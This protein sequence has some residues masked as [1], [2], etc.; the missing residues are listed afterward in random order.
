MHLCA[1]LCLFSCASEQR[2]QAVLDWTPKSIPAESVQTFSI[3][4]RESDMF[5]PWVDAYL[6]GGLRGVERLP[7][8]RNTYVFVKENRGNN[9]DALKQ[10]AVHFSVEREFPRLV[11]QRVQ[12]RLEGNVTTYP[13]NEYG[14]FFENAIKA[15][16]DARY[17]HTVKFDDFWFEKSIVAED[18]GEDRHEFLFLIMVIIEKKTLTDQINAI[19]STIPLIPAPTNS[20]LTAISHV[21]TAFFT[22]F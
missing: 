3:V 1:V 12:N 16:S 6:A 21:K 8:Y 9:L 17:E 14:V 13:D 15:F 18:G 7:A 4:S 22:R 10:W 2:P 20:Q 11:A 19:F 5:P